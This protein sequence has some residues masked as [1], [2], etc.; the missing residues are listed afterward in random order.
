MIR[1]VS[2]EYGVGHHLGLACS[3]S[4]WSEE[5]IA[6]I[7]SEVIWLGLEASSLHLFPLVITEFAARSI[8]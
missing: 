5:P 1:H 3:F 4:D 6:L 7:F 2:L 8:E